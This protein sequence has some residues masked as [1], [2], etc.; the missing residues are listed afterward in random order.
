MKAH[1]TKI[2]FTSVSPISVFVFFGALTLSSFAT[3]AAQCSPDQIAGTC[4]TISNRRLDQ[5]NPINAKII[6]GEIKERARAL[7]LERGDKN[8][9]GTQAIL[10]RLDSLSFREAP[11]GDPSCDGRP[12]RKLAPGNRAYARN[13]MTIKSRLGPTHREDMPNAFY[14]D[15]T[16]SVVACPS[17]L[18]LTAGAWASIFAHELGH[19]VSPCTLAKDTYQKGGAALAQNP[20]EVGQAMEKCLGPKAT[21]PQLAEAFYLLA[22]TGST[23]M[24]F[25]E[26]ILDRSTR[27]VVSKLKA[28][29]LLRK[30]A[31]A[32]TQIAP[33]FQNIQSC[34]QHKNQEPLQKMIAQESRPK[35]APASEP[36]PMPHIRGNADPKKYPA[37]CFGATEEEFADAFGSEVF[38]SWLEK[39][40]NPQTRSSEAL[41]QMRKLQCASAGQ[42]AHPEQDWAYPNY[43]T[44][45]LSIMNS[46]GFR[47]AQNCSIDENTRCYWQKTTSPETSEAAT[48]GDAA[49]IEESGRN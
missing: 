44:R 48:L 39:Q 2:T 5:G 30:T 19:V 3:A 32:Q 46:A 4:E 23:T 24:I 21:R 13:P 6:V 37:Q 38:G 1:H 43:N 36:N 20:E 14:N 11:E 17:A 22:E 9:P 45:L 26:N 12:N 15:G 18:R 40:N 41:T 29:G 16:H 25:P 27:S 31:D 10:A 28:C 47:K 49:S 34:L 33:V 8:D 35:K 7:I 42:P